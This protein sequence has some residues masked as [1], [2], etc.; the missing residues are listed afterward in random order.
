MIDLSVPD[1]HESLRQQVFA[2]TDKRG[3]DIIL[4]MLGGDVSMRRC[5]RWLG[6]AG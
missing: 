5:A 3:A 4:D 2:L 1:L 6:A